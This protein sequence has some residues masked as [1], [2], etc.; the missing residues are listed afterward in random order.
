VTT[1][2]GARP[3]DW[4]GRHPASPTASRTSASVT[5]FGALPLMLG[6]VLRLFTGDPIE[7]GDSASALAMAC[8]TS[9]GNAEVAGAATGGVPAWDDDA[10]AVPAWEDGV[11]A[12]G[13]LAVFPSCPVVEHAAK[14]P[15]AHN[16]RGGLR[17]RRA[18][19]SLQNFALV[20]GLPYQVVNATDSP[21]TRLRGQFMKLSRRTPARPQQLATPTA[22]MH[23]TSPPRRIHTAAVEPPQTRSAAGLPLA[24]GGF[25]AA[26]FGSGGIHWIG[27]FSVE[28]PRTFWGGTRTDALVSGAS[29]HL[30]LT[31]RA[32]A[33]DAVLA[34]GCAVSGLVAAASER[35]G[36]TRGEEEGEGLQGLLRT[37]AGVRSSSTSCELWRLTAGDGEQFL[38]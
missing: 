37:Q 18:P 25:F 27:A 31:A 34:R 6:S 19:C 5:S 29:L 12:T 10:D 20:T 2:S 11:E 32:Q 36:D 7:F 17:L 9:G 38:D 23:T 21:D 14:K 15:S 24:R 28:G 22:T 26:L 8:R 3:Y 35:R 13:S 33:L 30:E 1:N 16:S 4:S